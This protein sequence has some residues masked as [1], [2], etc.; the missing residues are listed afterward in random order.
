MAF[1][2][3]PLYFQILVVVYDLLTLDSGLL[4]SI[5]HSVIAVQQQLRDTQP[6]KASLIFFLFF[7]IFLKLF[8]MFFLILIYW[9]VK[10]SQ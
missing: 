7:R 9:S 8:L 5:S 1:N 2:F 3:L 4:T 6:D 10:I